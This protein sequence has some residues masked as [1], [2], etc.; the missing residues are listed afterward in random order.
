MIPRI[1]PP[2]PQIYRYRHYGMLL[3]GLGNDKSSRNHGKRVAIIVGSTPTYAA[4]AEV[5]DLRVA[6]C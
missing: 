3:R 4:A 2:P 1:L 6:A 5:M